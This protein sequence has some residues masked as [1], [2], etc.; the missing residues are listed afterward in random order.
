MGYLPFK[1]LKNVA[2]KL[3]S[4]E[5]F[6]R[7]LLPEQIWLELLL[8]RSRRAHDKI[9]RRFNCQY[10]SAILSTVSIFSQLLGDPFCAAK[11][12]SNLCTSFY[13]VAVWPQPQKKQFLNLSKNEFCSSVHVRVIEQSLTLKHTLVTLYPSKK[14]CFRLYL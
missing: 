14:T 2:W 11:S 5:L 13:T 6:W 3:L 7:S 1:L 12:A 4:L 8:P 10:G 9:N